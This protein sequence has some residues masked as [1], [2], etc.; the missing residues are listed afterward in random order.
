[1]KISRR[2]VGMIP[3]VRSP[4][5]R[6]PSKGPWRTPKM[7]MTMTMTMTKR[8]MEMRIARTSLAPVKGGGPPLDLRVGVP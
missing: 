5:L 4:L 1:M 7:M 6:P 8:M 3:V 2:V